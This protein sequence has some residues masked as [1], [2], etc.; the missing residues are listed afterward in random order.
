MR[1][2]VGSG[3]QWKRKQ[4]Q[5]DTFVPA[6]RRRTAF[7]LL[8]GF[9]HMLLW[10]GDILVLYAML[11]FIM[12]A[13]RELSPRAQLQSGVALMFFF[14]LS[15]IA[16]LV[17]GEQQTVNGALAHKIYPDMSGEAVVAAYASDS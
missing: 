9:L 12:I 13:L 3:L 15:H 2:R 7:L 16:A 10:S 6:Y 5:A 4:D 17:L 1:F 8:F 14:L 11:A